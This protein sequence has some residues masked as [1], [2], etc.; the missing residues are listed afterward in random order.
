[1][2]ENEIDELKEEITR[3]KQDIES[4][5][6]GGWITLIFTASL[7]FTAFLYVSIFL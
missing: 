5:K 2:N 4:F 3:R 1:M 6:R 7:I